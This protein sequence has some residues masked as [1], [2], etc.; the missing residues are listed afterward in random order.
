MGDIAILAG[1]KTGRDGIRGVTFASEELTEESEGSQRPAVQIANPI[2]EE[3]LR[4]A[5]LKILIFLI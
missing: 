4:R 1:G 2:E 5:I 3:K